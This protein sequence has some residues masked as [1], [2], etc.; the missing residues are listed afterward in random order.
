[1]S[2]F[3]RMRVSSLLSSRASASFFTGLPYLA[4]PCARLVPLGAR[5]ISFSSGSSNS[6]GS[7]SNR[8]KPT[9]PDSAQSPR[10]SPSPAGAASTPPAVAATKP[11]TPLASSLPHA[12]ANL[13]LNDGFFA[14][15][16]PL[17]ELPIRLSAR[18][19]VAPL[20]RLWSPA[21]EEDIDDRRAAEQERDEIE[22]FGREA[23]V[24]E[25]ESEIVQMVELAPDGVTPVGPP[26]MATLSGGETVE[27][28]RA[29]EEEEVYLDEMDR[30]ATEAAMDDIENGLPDPY[31]AWL[32]GTHDA[33]LPSSPAVSKYLAAHPPFSP[34]PAPSPRSAPRSS[35]AKAA[36]ASYAAQTL[37]DIS[38]LRPF[39]PATV[40]PSLHSTNPAFATHFLDPLPSGLS[41]RVADDFLAASI[42]SH[43]YLAHGDYART[44][45]EALE[46]AR[47]SYAPASDPPAVP[48]RAFDEK[49]QRGEV[50]L[51]SEEKG[52]VT[53]DF[54]RGVGGGSPFLPAE[55]VDLDWEEDQ[56][57]AMMTEGVRMDSVKRKRKKKITKHKFKKRRFV[58]SPS[59]SCVLWEE[60]ADHVVRLQKGPAGASPEARQ[61]VPRGEPPEPHF[62]LRFRRT[63]I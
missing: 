29:A 56:A 22:A 4:R 7:G 27:Q 46:L 13:I 17:L 24:Q 18:K 57:A 53:V 45:G 1:M 43:R 8:L 32:I 23:V 49:R 6:H 63:Q 44:A 3:G 60:N 10:P 48:R 35:S 30:E 9:L 37:S 62:L 36:T 34:P 15:H 5:S 12:N 40:S 51:W 50:R 14:L 26:F 52:W 41:A 21:A 2:G 39:P 47:Q 31:D 61:I 55:M 11:A 20:P 19:T 42:L 59:F 33:D 38:F 25:L 16:R 28:A 58:I 54:G